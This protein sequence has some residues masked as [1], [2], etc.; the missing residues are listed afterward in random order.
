MK[1]SEFV[2]KIESWLEILK[3]TPLSSSFEEAQFIANKINELKLLPPKTDIK[4]KNNNIICQDYCWD[5]E[6]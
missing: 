6:E 2:Y 1:Y 5:M 3:Q 4:D